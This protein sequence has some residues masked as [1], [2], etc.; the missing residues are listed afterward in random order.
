MLGILA[1]IFSEVFVY[2]FLTFVLSV[3]EIVLLALLA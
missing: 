3:V 2:C 1:F